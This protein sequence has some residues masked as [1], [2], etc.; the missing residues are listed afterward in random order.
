MP[1][2]IHHY[3]KFKM[4][5]PLEVV[6]ELK[7]RQKFAFEQLL[8]SEV[9]DKNF[10]EGKLVDQWYRQVF[11]R[12]TY[13][14]FDRDNNIRYIGEAKNGFFHRFFGHITTTPKP[15]FGFNSILRK[16]GERRTSKPAN[17]LLEVDH[18]TDLEELKKYSLLLIRIDYDYDNEEMDRNHPMAKKVE[19]LLL[20][21]FNEDSGSDLL[22]KRFGY[23]REHQKEQTFQEIIGI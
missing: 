6:K 15:N 11:I 23:L 1:V 9:L 7:A 17:E 8:V 13:L 20:K 10:L 4:L 19:S 21:A 14:F 5:K 22:N 18:L 3:N 16:L 2:S 12:G